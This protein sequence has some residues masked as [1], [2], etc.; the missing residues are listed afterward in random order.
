MLPTAVK[1][2]YW[3][4]FSWLMNGWRPAVRHIPIRRIDGP[5][6]S[7][8]AVGLY[9]RKKKWDLPDDTNMRVKRLR[10]KA[11]LTP[12]EAKLLKKLEKKSKS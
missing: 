6:P 12:D 3:K 1:P 7:F 2:P 11:R 5:I 8:R 10:K 9:S 4:I